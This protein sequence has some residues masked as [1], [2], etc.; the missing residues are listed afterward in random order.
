VK[1]PHG[2]WCSP[3]NRRLSLQLFRYLIIRDNRRLLC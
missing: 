3:T 2:S 1:M